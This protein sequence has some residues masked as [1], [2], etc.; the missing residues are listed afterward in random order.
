MTKTNKCP[1]FLFLDLVVTW[2]E[3]C[4]QVHVVV[5][6]YMRLRICFHFIFNKSKILG[7]LILLRFRSMFDRI[8]EHI[9][10]LLSLFDGNVAPVCF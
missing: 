6:I 4:V 8:N 1:L 5:D 9:H 10:V 2:V 3:C 7:P